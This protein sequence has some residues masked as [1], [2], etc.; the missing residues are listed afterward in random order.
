MK[1]DPF[2]TKAEIADY[3]PTIH[4]LFF[5][6]NRT[7]VLLGAAKCPDKNSFPSLPCG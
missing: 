4:S 2:L 1:V 7:P 5:L 3:L 6:T